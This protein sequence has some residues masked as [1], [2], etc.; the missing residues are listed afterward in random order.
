VTTLAIIGCGHWGQNYLR[1]FW[2]L[3]EARVA[4]CCDASPECARR[5]GGRFSGVRV[6]TDPDEVFRSEEVDAVAIATPAATHYELASRAL[7]T[8]KHVLVEKPMTTSAV[9]ARRLAEQSEAA[10]RIIMVGHVFRYHPALERVK[11][12]I[13]EGT[14][15]KIH[16]I[17]S[18]RTNLGPIRGDVSALWDLAAHDVSIA[19]HLLNA[20]PSS[21][22][23]RGG[24]F[25]QAGIEDVVFFT[26]I[27]PGGVMVNVHVSWLDPRKTREITIVGSNRMVVFDDMN[28]L[29]PI[30]I[31]DKTVL[32]APSYANFGEFRLVLRT[33]DILVPRVEAREPLKE[34]CRHFLECVRTGCPPLSGARDGERVCRVLEAVDQSIRE[35]GASVPV[36]GTGPARVGTAPL[37]A[38]SLGPGLSAASADAPQI[39]DESTPLPVVVAASGG[40]V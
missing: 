30:R 40:L 25:L 22:S 9:H 39:P 37:R 10:G 1:N 38:A 31:Y 26:M 34:Q 7:A 28:A 15:G 17:H 2:E 20:M 35:G 23:A 8:G 18:T 4:F 5:F 3:P 27:F 24:C 29:E 6:T 13:G 16:Y 11:L 32:Q 33:G 14:F 21:V 12:L 19:L 36:P